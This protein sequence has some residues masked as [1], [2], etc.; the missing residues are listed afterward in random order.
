MPEVFPLT[1]EELLHVSEVLADVDAAIQADMRRSEEQEPEAFRDLAR[2]FERFHAAN[3]GVYATLVRLARRAKQEGH[4]QIGISMLWEIMRWE[5]L[6]GDTKL[7]EG[8]KLNNNHR[9]FFARR[10]MEQEP[11]LEGMFATRRQRAVSS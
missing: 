7:G 4:T 3:P 2:S 6:V 9:A 11:D 10:I 1:Q 8:Y 5:V